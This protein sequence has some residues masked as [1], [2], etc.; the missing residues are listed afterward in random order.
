MAA[1]LLKQRI[2]AMAKDIQVLIIEDDPYARD[3]MTLLLTRDWRTH[4]IGEIA[5]QH[6]SNP[7]LRPRYRG[8]GHSDRK[9]CPDQTCL[10]QGRGFVITSQL[11]WPYT[12]PFL[13]L[14]LKGLQ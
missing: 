8:T 10:W 9:F 2:I 3:L 6:E 7:P 4:V 13:R 12:Y 5:N 14:A 11:G 1:L